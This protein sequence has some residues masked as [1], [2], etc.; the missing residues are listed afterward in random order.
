MLKRNSF[1]GGRDS[2]SIEN[3]EVCITDGIRV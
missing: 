2:G 3:G 1:Q